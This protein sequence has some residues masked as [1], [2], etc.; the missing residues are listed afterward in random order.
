MTNTETTTQTTET[1][2]VRCGN[3]GTWD[4]PKY[5]P[6]VQD[7]KDCFAKLYAAKAAVVVH[8]VPVVSMPE[9][10]V[11]DHQPKRFGRWSAT[12]YR[13]GCKTHL[14]LDRP[15]TLKCHQH[16]KVVKVKAKQLIG[17]LSLSPKHHCDSSCINAVGPVCVCSCGGAGHGVGW[18]TKV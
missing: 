14:V 1:P 11:I 6:T 3:C 18:L 4:A 12:C 17:T 7:V 5:H 2:Q 10:K 9:P 16:G 8:H 15:F 13:T